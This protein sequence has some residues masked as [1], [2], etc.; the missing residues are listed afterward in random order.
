MNQSEAW[1]WKHNWWKME[2]E[3]NRRGIKK[4][5]FIYEVSIMKLLLLNFHIKDYIS[6]SLNHTCGFSYNHYLKPLH[7][8]FFLVLTI[9]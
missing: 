2:H 4:T 6:T 1:K 9:T 3:S 8:L 7:N 5:E